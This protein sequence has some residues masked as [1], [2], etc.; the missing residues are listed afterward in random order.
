[1]KY[2]CSLLAS[3][4][5]LALL[6][7]PASADTPDAVYTLG[8]VLVSAAPDAVGGKAAV[9]VSAE[10]IR[11]HDKATVGQA[12]A[13][14][15]GV[16]LTKVGAR[17]EE[18]IRI[19]GFDLRQ[20]PVFVDGIPVYVPYDGYVDLA[21]FT[22]FDLARIDV[23]KGF[24]STVYGP[25][26]LGG[27]VNLISRRPTRALE[28]EIG[29]GASLTADGENNGYRT[30]GNFGTNQGKWYAQAGASYLNADYFRLADDF[31]PASG[32]DGGRRDNSY[33]QDRKYNL[34]LGYTP[35]ADDE[36]SI[37]YIDQHGEKGT[38]PYAGSL[39]SARYWKWPYWDKRSLYFVSHTVIGRHSLKVRAYHDTYEN[40][41]FAYDDASYT[42][43]LKRSSFKSW[44][45]DYSNGAS[46]ADDIRLSAANLLKLAYHWKED[47]HRE[48]DAGEPLQ[49]FKDRTQ[50][51]A[52]EDTQQLTS[53]LSAVA[54]LSFDWRDAL[55]AEDYSSATGISS[56][57]LGDVHALNAQVGLFQDI[58]PTARLHASLARKSRFP[59]IKDRF[60]Y[61][62][63]TA[64]P[65]PDLKVEKANHYEIGY[66]D[67][68]AGSLLWSANLFH[69]DIRDLIQSE[70]IDDSL[71]SSP[72][73]SQMKN[74][75][76]ASSSGLE[77]GL[78]ANLDTWE[79]GLN[80][81]WLHRKNHE[82]DRVKLTDTP[83][84][85]LF[86]YAR[87]Q[88]GDT[89][90]LQVSEEAA[91]RRYSNSSGS[92]IAAGYAITNIKATWLL[93][94]QLELAASINNLFDRNYAYS[95]GF[96]EPG[97]NALLQ[98]NWQL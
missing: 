6:A 22:T 97:R 90:T 65:N 1:M 47:I 51:L 63:G 53:A 12:I 43:Q 78:N 34:K 8:E 40:S 41:L 89:L 69:S 48:H 54:G 66:E 29:A 45:D 4:P 56:F 83:A 95:E 36:Y 50:S 26:T 80:Y 2:P 28:G 17:N 64:I 85:S 5:L 82:D 39:S 49:R 67:V 38:P 20:T 3:M 14:T 24:S 91:S 23:E 61:R 62:L 68:L 9:S 86:A 27:A 96:P 21:R 79:L 13:L 7:S 55:R 73:C 42:S 33:H 31:T 11:D 87:W 16:T 58:G 75:G 94:P 37:S 57:E 92:Q 44:Y 25:N 72:P 35:N 46:V 15:P 98:F 76:K 71:C 52:L 70:S 59:T 30:W 84:H 60:S 81:T 93:L 18:M 19:R 74:V 88:A 10:T 77:L 32:E